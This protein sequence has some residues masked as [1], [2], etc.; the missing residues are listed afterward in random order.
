[1]GGDV[2]MKNRPSEDNLLLFATELKK[3]YNKYKNEDK[4]KDKKVS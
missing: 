3:L 4:I 1:M 2:K